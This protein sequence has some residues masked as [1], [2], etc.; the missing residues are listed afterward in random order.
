MHHVQ[1]VGAYSLWIMHAWDLMGF[2]WICAVLASGGI[3]FRR[4]RYVCGAMPGLFLTQGGWT[5]NGTKTAKDPVSYGT[6]GPWLL[7]L[8]VARS[9]SVSRRSP[10]ASGNMQ[11]FR[12]IKD[13]CKVC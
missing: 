3:G 10:A 4:V 13:T 5:G 7:L 11:G 12:E 1:R 2:A 9:M 8:S 6:P